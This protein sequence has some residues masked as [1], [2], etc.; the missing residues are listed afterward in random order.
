MAPSARPSGGTGSLRAGLRARAGSCSAFA[1]LVKI[2]PRLPEPGGRAAAAGI[3]PWR[4]SAVE[5]VR[6][7]APEP[8][9]PRN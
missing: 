6:N 2:L 9:Q 8:A 7:I 4:G 1:E 3:T 5:R